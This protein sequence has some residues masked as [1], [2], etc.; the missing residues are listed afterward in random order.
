MA[1]YQLRKTQQIPAG[2]DEVWNFISSPENLKRITPPFMGFDITTGLQSPKMYPGMIIGY[3]VSPV[4]GIRMTWVTEITQVKEKHYFVDE[5]RI[6][7]Y[8]LWHHEHILETFEGGVLMTDIVSYRPPFGF[9]GS[10]ANTLFI[11][12]QLGG[13]FKYRTEAMEKIFGQG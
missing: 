13:I 8:A 1:F 7:P 6:G 12:R 2:I 4:L 3:K 9:I 10:I 11:K 5:Q